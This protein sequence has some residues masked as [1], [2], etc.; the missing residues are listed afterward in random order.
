[1]HILLL[2]NLKKIIMNKKTLCTVLL[3]SLGII[4]C[5]NEDFLDYCQHQTVTTSR[6][7]SSKDDSYYVKEMAKYL[8][9]ATQN[10]DF[11]SLLAN[12][13]KQ[14][15]DGDY[16]ILL[17]KSFSTKEK[18]E[19]P[20][21][22][23]F[24]NNISQTISDNEK[25]ED[26]ISFLNEVQQKSPLLNIYFPQDSCADDILNSQ[27]FFTVVLDPSFS[28]TNDST[29]YAYNKNGEIVELSANEEPEAPYIVVGINE[30]ITLDSETAATRCTSEPIFKNEYYS[31]Y[32]P[33]CFN[34]DKETFIPSTYGSQRGDRSTPDIISRAKF[35][36]SDAIK[37]VEGWFRGA[38]EV[39]LTVIYADKSPAD[40]ILGPL[41][42]NL[43][44][45]LGENNWYTGPRRK[46]KPCNNFGNWYITNWTNCQKTYMKYHFHEMDN[47]FKVTI[48]GWE[49]QFSGGNLIGDVKVNYTDNLGMT[50]HL[51]SMFEFDL[52]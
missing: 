24:I 14:Q 36:S 29:V 51:G 3:L 4:S 38:P 20:L 52:K 6:S 25:N 12:E 46:K 37:E 49:V 8:N 5:Q 27:E 50:Y 30:R 9:Q 26:F 17:A 1:M 45:N 15:I 42:H 18:S 39:H 41:L 16:D 13:A 11:I 22:N 7:I 44:Y 43:Q 10:K 48:N 32:L 34:K 31:F 28:D 23:S 19:N 47:K 2:F 21:L 35:K 33:D 40:L